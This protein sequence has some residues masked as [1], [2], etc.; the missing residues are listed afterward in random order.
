LLPAESPDCAANGVATSRV[1]ALR[2]ARIER[3][4][5]VAFE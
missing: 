2:G 5:G 3:F 1:R 4:I